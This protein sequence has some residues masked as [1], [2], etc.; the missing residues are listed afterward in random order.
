MTTKKLLLAEDDALL[1]S[2]LD[3]RLKKNGYEVTICVDGKK[4]KEYLKTERPDIIVTD[5]MMPYFSGLELTDY[6][7]NQ[8][9]LKIP[10]IVL[11]SAGN[12]ENV[13]S[14]FNLGAND[15]LA[16]PVSPAELLLRLHKELANQN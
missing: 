8:L 9:K 16:K 5:I 3:Y 15:F 6:V 14:A 2:L 13:L 11:S 7:R 1:A 4:V 10:I 12:E